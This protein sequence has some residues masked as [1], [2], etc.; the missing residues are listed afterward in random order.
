MKLIAL[1]TIGVIFP[2]IILG[3]VLMSGDGGF[4]RMTT[5]SGVYTVKEPDGYP[6]VCFIEKSSGSMECLR[7]DEGKC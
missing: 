6:V 3:L 4:K 1:I 5:L 2:F 7:L